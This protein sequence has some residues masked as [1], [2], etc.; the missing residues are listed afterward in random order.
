MH[1]IANRRSLGIARLKPDS[2]PLSILREAL[3]AANWAPSNGDTEPW[4]FIVFTGEGRRKL[5]E[6]FSTAYRL[7][8]EAE[9]SFKKETFDAQYERGTSS[10]VWIAIGMVP[11]LLPDGTMKESEQEEMMAVACAVQNMH[12]VLAQHGLIGM[13]HS[14]GTSVHPYVAKILGWEPPARL[15]GFFFCGWPN[16][17]WPDG[18]RGHWEDKVR[19]E[20]G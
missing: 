6:A 17:D 1:S 14:K 15:L 7:E 5:S 13:W 10:P 16:V 19:W 12:L 4:R 8:A 18:E 20:S 9:G 11:G 2:V 3:E